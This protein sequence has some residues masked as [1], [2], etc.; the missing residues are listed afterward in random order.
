MSR[1]P[2]GPLAQPTCSGL[3]PLSHALLSFVGVGRPEGVRPKQKFPF[4]VD[5]RLQRKPAVGRRTL[6]DAFRRPNN[7]CSRRARHSDLLIC[8]RRTA[9]SHAWSGGRAVLSRRDGARRK[10]CGP[11]SH[12][13]FRRRYSWTAT[14]IADCGRKLRPNLAASYALLGK[15]D[16]AKPSV[17]ETL[18][19][20][21]RFT[22]KWLREHASD[23]PTRTEGVRKAVAEE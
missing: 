20:N 22:I 6:T 1:E 17:A 4:L 13:P 21:P 11:T 12:T 7:W 14:T 15:I 16:E 9:P 2:F 19:L 23:I 8:V 10:P 18:R 5:D 3:A